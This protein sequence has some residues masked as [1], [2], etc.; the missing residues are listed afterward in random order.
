MIPSHT[1][2]EIKNRIDI[3]EVVS[4]FVSLKRKGQSMW[5]CC[6]FHNEKSPSF[7]VSPVKGF[8]KCFGCGKS[9]DALDFVMEMEKLNYVESLKFLAKKYGIEVQEK[10]LTDDQAQQQSER[11]SLYIVLNAAKEYFTS[12]LWDSQE[13]RAIGLSYFQE[14]KMTD[15]IL[16]KFEL[17]FVKD[18]WDGFYTHALKN[19]HTEEMLE[20]AGLLIVKEN[21]KYDRFRGRVI[22]PIHNVSGRVVGFGARALKKDDKPKYINSPETSVYVKNQVLYGMFQA[23]QA[24][25]MA[26]N[27]FLVEGYTDVTSLHEVGIENVVASSGTSLTE[28]QIKLIQRFSPTITVLYDGDMA[29]IKA[30]LRGIDMI[31]AQ[32]LNVKMVLLPEGEDPDSYSK[33]LG[34]EKFKQYLEDKKEDFI[35]FKANLLAQEAEKDPIKKAESIKEIVSSIAAIPDA[36]KRTVYI[37]EAGD[38]LQIEEQVLIG[39]LNKILRKKTKSSNYSKTE[40]AVPVT[41]QPSEQ[42]AIW[43]PIE[44]IKY[45]EQESIRLLLEYAH[46]E[47]DQ[48]TSLQSYLL[49]ELEDVEFL[50]EIHA[51]IF[52]KFREELGKGNTA[53]IDY[54]I[55]NGSPEVRRTVI[56]IISKKRDISSKWKDKHK[57]FVPE[58]SEK[59]HLERTALTNILRLKQRVVRKML[60]D[61]IERLKSVSNETE[62]TEIQQIHSELKKTETEIASLLGN[63]ILK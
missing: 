20:K 36:I 13:G 27:C 60:E 38:L 29:G 33:A 37:K 54:F 47:L 3:V 7:S 39:E 45:Q 32:G 55:K 52:N 1:V 23:K 56:D 30:S 40:E 35:H 17:G 59:S 16:K 48:E 53:T 49:N 24:I 9:G 50:S 6:P 11:E 31:L 22:F 41:L 2:D 34:A 5:A 12:T 42:E 51:E 62:Q 44:I 25:R 58:E 43:D 8:Y 28:G 18:E 14:R 26:E 61:N 4:D 21:K 63:V 10:E 46:V 15:A 19:G 57:I